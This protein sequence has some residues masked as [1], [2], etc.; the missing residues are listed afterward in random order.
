[1]SYNQKIIGT[2]MIRIL[3]AGMT[4]LIFSAHIMMW[5]V[6]T[7]LIEKLDRITANISD[8]EVQSL[9]KVRTLVFFSSGALTLGFIAWAYWLIKK[10]MDKRSIAILEVKQQKDILANFLEVATQESKRKSAFLNAVSHDMRTPL[11]T[12]GLQAQLASMCI[13]T[14][15][16]IHTIDAM[17]SIQVAVRVTSD[18]L[19]DLIEMGRMETSH[20]KVAAEYFD[21]SGFLP[22]ICG[23]ISPKE[24]VEFVI[25]AEDRLRVHT[26][27][28]KLRRI[29]VNLVDNAMKFTNNGRVSL[30][31]KCDGQGLLVSVSDTGCGMSAN[32]LIHIYEEFFQ[33]GNP[34]RDRKKGF[35]LG[36]SI[37]KRLVGVLGGTVKVVSVPDKGTEF[38][39]RIPQIVCTEGTDESAKRTVSVSC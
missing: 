9:I 22:S 39:V 3:F 6:G 36:L 20:E 1:M 2:R 35:G 8:Q 11:N 10:E 25:E 38:I 12:I 16:E 33:A 21:I 18:L 27:K 23:S 30:V 37:V 19:N 13:G 28:L 29:V 31:M 14:P 5:K 17:K 7:N 34:E 24:T 26:D 32:V 4:A 15:D